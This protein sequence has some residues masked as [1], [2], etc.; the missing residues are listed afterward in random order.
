MAAKFTS[1]RRRDTD[2]EDDELDWACAKVLFDGKAHRSC[3]QKISRHSLNCTSAL[4]QAAVCYC[5]EDNCNGAGR[6][7]AIGG[8]IAAVIVAW[9]IVKG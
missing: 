3:V 1:R 5:H 2:D 6:M 7:G 8:S 9:V 4:G